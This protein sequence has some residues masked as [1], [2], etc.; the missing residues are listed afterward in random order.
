MKL[1]SVAQALFIVVASVAVYSFVRAAQ[2]DQRFNSCQAWCQLR[3]N[4]AGRD[5]SA[6]D[7][8]LKNM[9]GEVRRLSDLL[10]QGPVV[11]NFWTKTCQPCL[12]EMPELADMARVLKSQGVT[13][14]TVC[15]D[16]GPEAVR[17][18][19]DVV[20]QGQDPPFEVLFDP[21]GERVVEKKFGTSL[22][23]E[24][25]LIDR[26]GIIRARIDGNPGQRDMPWTSSIPFEVLESLDKPMSCPV[27]FRRGVPSGPYAN[28]CGEG[29]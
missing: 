21:D 22:F 26:E 13:V 16:D 15:T 18:T 20:L 29:Y 4:Y 12:E 9:N 8:A 2:A 25:W 5:R 27:D 23:P 10:G 19:L 28:L 6:P 17:D 11:L 24:T 3:P 14:V 7:F 1:A